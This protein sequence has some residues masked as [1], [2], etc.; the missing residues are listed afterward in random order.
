MGPEENGADSLDF[1]NYM[2]LDFIDIRD[3]QKLSKAVNPIHK[4][5]KF[6]AATIVL[7]QDS[8]LLRAYDNPHELPKELANGKI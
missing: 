6:F 2:Q 3:N 5:K 8:P 7:Q 1:E 4:V